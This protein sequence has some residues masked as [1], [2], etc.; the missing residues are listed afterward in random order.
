M[1]RAALVTL[2]LAAC[3]QPVSAP[4]PSALG[5][6]RIGADIYPIEATGAGTWRVKV[7]GHPVVCSKPTEEA[8]TWSVRHYLTAQELLDDLG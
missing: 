1:H 2:L 8:C 3:A 5:E 7:D 6:V 4:A